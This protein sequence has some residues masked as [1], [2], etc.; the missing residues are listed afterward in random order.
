MGTAEKQAV[1]ALNVPSATQSAWDLDLAHTSVEFAVK[2]LMIST[3]TGRMKLARG[4]I[5]VD[6]GR[7]ESATVDVEIDA[8]SLDTGVA[9]RDLHLRSPDFFDVANHPKIVFKST[10]AQRLG[11]TTGKLEGELTVR[12]VTR[13]VTLDV[14]FEGEGID[15]WGGR[16]AGFTGTATLNRK[17]FGVSWNMVLDS[18]GVLVGD[19]A[20]ITIHAEAVR[21]KA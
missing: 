5:L 19:K 3:V 11:E 18:G 14:E 15:P 13:P 7:P 12:G 9:D 8:G 10:R 6:E 1:Q 21:R 2:H 16:R 20:K 4:Q 17:D